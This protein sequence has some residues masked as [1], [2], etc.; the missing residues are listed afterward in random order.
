MPAAWRKGRKS[1]P[2]LRLRST[3]RLLRWR[4]AGISIAAGAVITVL[5][6]WSIAL[7]ADPDPGTSD[8]RA[9]W[10]T[11]VSSDWPPSP[12]S[13]TSYDAQFGPSGLR[14]RSAWATDASRRGSYRL[15]VSDAGWPAYALRSTIRSTKIVDSTEPSAE[16]RELALESGLAVELH[17]S[18]P[19]VRGEDGWR[20]RRLP[21]QPLP[22]GFGASMAFWAMPM[23]AL[24][25]LCRLAKVGRCTEAVGLFR[26]VRFA[27]VVVSLAAAVNACV[28]IGLWARWQWSADP[29]ALHTREYRRGESVGRNAAVLEGTLASWPASVPEDWPETPRWIGWLGEAPGVRGYEYTSN[30][31]PAAA[32]IWFHVSWGSGA[33]S[34]HQQINV[35]QIGWP[36]ACLQSEELIEDED[37]D[38]IWVG[39]QIRVSPEAPSD[40]PF[41]TV[42]RA[43]RG[44][45]SSLTLPGAPQPT[46]ASQ[47]TPFL[48]LRPLALG[49]VVNTLLFAYLIALLLVGPAAVR[50]WL[51]IR[52]SRCVACGYSIDGMVRCPECGADV[53]CTPDA[54]EQVDAGAAQA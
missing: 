27:L 4:D 24:L 44:V 20:A 19:H 7:R 54:V 34:D 14:Q 49:M 25:V 52:R 16:Q 6:A 37:H 41:G 18:R 8:E 39:L 2:G 5:V 47:P 10:P 30:G 32:V 9:R 53:N 11:T 23:L 12:R 15:W 35:V 42:R 36:L 40:A 50:T 21:L 17:H 51:R 22:V 33:F 26:W 1:V 43:R 48:P 31:V 3:T 45:I 46:W 29:L 38:S 28:A 13:V